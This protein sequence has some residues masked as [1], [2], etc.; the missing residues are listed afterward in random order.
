[1]HRPL[2]PVLLGCLLAG[3]LSGCGHA[4]S[5]SVPAEARSSSAAEPGGGAPAVR[6]TT[7][8]PERKDLRLISSQP[9]AI[10]AWETTPLHTK[11]A[12]FVGEIRADIGDRVVKDQLLLQLDVPELHDEHR[13]QQA[14]LAQAEAEVGQAQA[15]L[16]AA[17]AAVATAAAKIEETGAGV[18]RA[19]ATLIQQQAEYARIE[20]LVASRSVTQSLFDEAAAK[21]RAAEAAQAAAA[22]VVESA[23]AGVTQ[24]E[25][26]VRKS[27]A[28]LV[29]AQARRDVAEANLARAATMLAYTEIKAP[30]DGVITTRNV[31]TGH[32]VQPAAAGATPLMVI[33][34]TQR[35]RIFI[36]VPEVEAGWVD[37]GENGDSVTIRVP[38]LAGREFTRPVTRTSWALDD[39]NRSLR[40]EIDCDNPDGA[41]RPGMY[42]S[43]TIL[44][45]ER[46]DVLTLP[47]TAVVRTDDGAY[48]CV[49]RQN[50]AVHT[51]VET[52]LR[53]DE[54]VEIVSGLAPDAV[55]VL[56]GVAALSDGAA[57]EVIAGE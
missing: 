19:E 12:G 24:A 13:Q 52:G 8:T 4:T 36:D 6:V 18:T 44:L 31:D 56:S 35:V 43:A 34:S 3:F 17:R 22:A 37:S 9:A 50:K 28:D 1:M 23:R 38:A 20:Q 16:E 2:L 21:L 39:K 25:A 5:A 33:S 40:S 27:E 48:C 32:Y 42:A 53:T 7:V 41:L 45:E 26:G 51:P 54:G 49:V 11:I 55:V 57:V 14:L 47:A 30:Y 29:A 15:E 10:E 46:N